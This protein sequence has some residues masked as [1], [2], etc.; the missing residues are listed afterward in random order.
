MDQEE[1]GS[2]FESYL[3]H[4][5]SHIIVPVIPQMSSS[6]TQS[7]PELTM[8]GYVQL[9]VSVSRHSHSVYDTHVLL[10]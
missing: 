5:Q 2:S 10:P 8:A 7:V 3:S 9:T 1:E 4:K 6:N